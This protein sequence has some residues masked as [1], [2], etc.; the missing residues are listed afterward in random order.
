[1]WGERISFEIAVG[2]I[3]LPSPRSGALP[4]DHRSPQYYWISVPLVSACGDHCSNCTINGAGKCDTG[5]CYDKYLLDSISLTCGGKCVS[6]FFITVRMFSAID[7][8][9]SD[10]MGMFY[11]A[12]HNNVHNLPIHHMTSRLAKINK[13]LM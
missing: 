12:T 3:E 5:S 2:R 6:C 8:R 11:I 13:L 4:R 9:C 10:Q 1:M 7:P